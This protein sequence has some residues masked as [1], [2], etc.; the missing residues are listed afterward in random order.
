V[1]VAEFEDLIRS[2]VERTVDV[3]QETI[4]QAN[5]SKGISGIYVAGGSSRI[6]LVSRI[7]SERLGRTPSMFGDPKAVTALG[8]LRAPL[9]KPPTLLGAPV[10]TG[11]AQVGQTL[12]VKTGSFSSSMPV[13]ELVEWQRRAP[14]EVECIVVGWAAQPQASPRQAQQ[15]D[16]TVVRALQNISNYTYQSPMA[17]AHNFRA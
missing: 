17:V 7:L 12:A 2:D 16:Q 4:A 14:G 9:I 11:K 5:S 10:L 8:A 15:H 13:S 1:T 3:L 6:P